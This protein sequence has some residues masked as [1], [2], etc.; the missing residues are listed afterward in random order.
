MLREAGAGRRLRRGRDGGGGSSFLDLSDE[1][2]GRR[3]G[4]LDRGAGFIVV[5]V[6]DEALA[7]ESHGCSEEVQ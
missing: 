7:G 1:A 4:G 2:E 6:E 5:Q 3:G